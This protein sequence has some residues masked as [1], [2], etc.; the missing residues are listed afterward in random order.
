MRKTKYTLRI[1][2]CE[3]VRGKPLLHRQHLYKFKIIELLN[4]IIFSKI[5]F[6]LVLYFLLP[7][8]TH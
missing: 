2:F 1:E 6:Y 8:N 4:L 7:V 3:L 5:S